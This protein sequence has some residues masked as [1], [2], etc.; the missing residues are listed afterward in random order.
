[1]KGLVYSLALF[2]SA[3]GAAI[4]MALAKVITDPNLVI[5]WIVLAVISFVCAFLFPT[6]FKHL[7]QHEFTWSEEEKEARQVEAKKGVEA[8]DN[9]KY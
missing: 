5:P 8:G 9:D 3:I 7:D 2:N 6:Y 1:M 4:S